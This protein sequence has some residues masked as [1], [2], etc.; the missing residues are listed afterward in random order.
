MADIATVK[1]GSRINV[2]VVKQPTSVAAAK[3]IARVLCKDEEVAAENRRQRKVRD[4]NYNPKMR[5]GRL[6]GG[7]V[8]KQHA[9]KGEIGETGVIT[10]TVDVIRDLQSVS[11]FIEVGSTRQN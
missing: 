8:V 6:Y 2:K 5:G 4:R 9:A 11:R 7:R 1:P 3:T 10:A